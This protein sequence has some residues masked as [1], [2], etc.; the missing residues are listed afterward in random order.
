MPTPSAPS[1][2]V[3]R[4]GSAAAEGIEKIVPVAPAPEPEQT[5]A[6]KMLGD[7]KQKRDAE[8]T[9]LTQKDVDKA[10]A[11]ADAKA[12]QREEETDAERREREEEE[13]DQWEL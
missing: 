4:N 8:S 11:E 2:A 10:Q 9:D 6:E 1:Y 13:E 3:R 5:K 7:L 12:K